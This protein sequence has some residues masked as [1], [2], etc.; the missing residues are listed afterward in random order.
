[1][2]CNVSLYGNISAK[3]PRSMSTLHGRSLS[4][5]QC[6]CYE[7]LKATAMGLLSDHIAYITLAHLGRLLVYHLCDPTGFQ[8]LK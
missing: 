5:Q 1:M 7:S 3:R 6:T 4:H 2:D 8:G